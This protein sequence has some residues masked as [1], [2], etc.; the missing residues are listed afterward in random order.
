MENKNLPTLQELYSNTEIA[1]KENALNILLNHEPKKD[2]LRLHPVAK[3]VLYIPIERIEYLLTNIF[4][5]W[6]VEIKEIKLIANS[7]V[8]TVRLHY[9]DPVTGEMQF[10]DGIG[11]APLQTEKNAGAIEF[12]KIKSNAVMLAAPSAESYAI[13]DAAEKLGKLFGK[14]LNRSDKIMYDNIGKK[15]E[16]EDQ[17]ISQ[18]QF[19]YIESLIATS[20]NNDE[21]RYELGLELTALTES[22]AEAFIEALKNNQLSPQ[23]RG[24]ESQTE[25]ANF[26]KN[27][28]D[29]PRS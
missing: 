12:D 5:V 27:K 21:E 25:I 3:G 28:V 4:Q 7:V 2:W 26:V 24:R 10:H 9:K 15:F 13:K 18:Q 8:V 16:E 14:D 11:G 19:A 6:N 20:N 1:K 17:L 29:D 23:E 22:K